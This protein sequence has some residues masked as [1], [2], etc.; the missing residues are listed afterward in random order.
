MSPLEEKDKEMGS[1]P[2][3]SDEEDRPE[4]KTDANMMPEVET[5]AP[6]VQDEEKG[7]AAKPQFPPF[8]PMNNP[9]GG[10][11]AWM[12]VAGGWCCL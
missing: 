6:E 4:N 11:Q 5:R 3:S 2:A 7:T 8:H 1:S 10:Q 12:T 9:D